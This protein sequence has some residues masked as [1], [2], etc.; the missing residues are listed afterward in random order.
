MASITEADVEAFGRALE[1]AQWRCPCALQDRDARSDPLCLVQGSEGRN[2]RQGDKE[3]GQSIGMD[4]SPASNWLARQHDRK[5]VVKGFFDQR[6]WSVQYVVS[7]P[8]TRQ[9]VIIDPVLDFDE[10][11]GA[12]SAEHALEILSY[13]EANGLSVQWILDTHPHAD[14]FLRRSLPCRTHGRTDG[15]RRR[16]SMLA[17]MLR[18]HLQRSDFPAD[19]TH[20][21]ANCLPMARHSAL[22]TFR[23]GGDFLAG[24]ALASVTHV[25]HQATLRLFMTQCS[26][27][28]AGRHEPIFR[29][30]TPVCCG[31]PCKQSW[32]CRNRP[33]SS[34][35]T[36]TSLDGRAPGGK[37]Q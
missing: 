21:G 4:L 6:T 23:Q 31:A 12:T 36:I 27:Q 34:P 13:V 25:L 17:N 19:G 11:S 32:D 30:A 35:A 33:A 2:D 1:Q 3:F 7:G 24:H 37:A 9:C 22:E 20:N 10:K 28:I 8:Q 5:P 29:G 14:H 15:S 26:C 16:L 18:G